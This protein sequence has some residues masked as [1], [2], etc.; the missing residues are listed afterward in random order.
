MQTN[1]DVE[2]I[3]NG[4]IVRYSTGLVNQ[5]YHAIYCASLECVAETILMALRETYKETNDEA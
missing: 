3:D 4:Y 5:C 1:Y 2:M